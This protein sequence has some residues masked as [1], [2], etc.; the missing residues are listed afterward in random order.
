MGDRELPK[1]A[2]Q[3]KGRRLENLR[4]VPGSVWPEHRVRSAERRGKG[5]WDRA[6]EAR[7]K[8]LKCAQ[9]HRGTSNGLSARLIVNI[10]EKLI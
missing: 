2:A 9:R 7:L 10:S 6:L 1:E 3:D 8:N 4:R 5:S